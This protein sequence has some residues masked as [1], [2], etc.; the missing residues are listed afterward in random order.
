MSKEIDDL[1]ADLAE[2]KQKRSKLYAE[3]SNEVK[4]ASISADVSL[5]RQNL[6]SSTS[7]PR[8][9]LGSLED[10]RRRTDEFLL[11]CEGAAVVPTFLGLCTALGYT[12]QGIYHFLGRSPGTESAK[13]IELAREVLADALI[14]SSLTR[15]TDA[16]TT[17]FALKNLHGFL[18]WI[19]VEAVPPDNP[20]GNQQSA[21]QLAE[22]YAELPED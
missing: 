3:V 7:R 17:I 14:T 15:T 21:E 10:V 8:A 2:R 13:F 4:A 5:K 16:A 1:T 19:S 12:R 11:A 18:D 20:L 9:D 22:R 6:M